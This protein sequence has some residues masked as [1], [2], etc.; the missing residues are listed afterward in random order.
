MRERLSVTGRPRTGRGFA[1][2][3]PDARVL[4][5]KASETG[6]ALI[7]REALVEDAAAIARVYVETARAQYVAIVA[8][9]ALHR[10]ATAH[11]AGRW[12]L[13]LTKR[14]WVRSAYIAEDAQGRVV[15][16][17][18]AGPA[19]VSSLGQAGELYAIYVLPHRQRRGLGRLLFART[20]ESLAAQGVDA[21]V[22]RV[23]A[24]N[25]ARGF[26]EALSGTWVASASSSGGSAKVAYVWGLQTKRA[27][28]LRRI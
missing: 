19:R 25:P 14:R 5:E 22:A 15:G 4:V 24:A 1:F 7:V 28:S 17:A 12:E 11:L 2:S 13:L 26:F 21:I 3:R 9:P 16:F 18:A 23:F 27:T 6:S 20:V 10:L 8:K